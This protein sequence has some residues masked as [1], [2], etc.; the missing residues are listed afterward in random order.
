MDMTEKERSRLSTLYFDGKSRTQQSF[1][2][3]C[4]INTIIKRFGKTGLVPVGM[5]LPQYGDFSGVVDYQSALHVL[6]EADKSFSMLPSDIRKRFDN[7][8]QKFV[9]FAVDPANIAALQDLG[10][11]PKPVVVDQPVGHT[12]E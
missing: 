12:T 5:R 2:A 8:P 3:E 9:D 7:D 4:D 6:M 11:A 1:V 10:L